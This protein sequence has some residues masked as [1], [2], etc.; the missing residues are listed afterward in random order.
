MHEMNDQD[1]AELE[2]RR[3]AARAARGRTAGLPTKWQGLRWEDLD[4]GE[5]GARSAAVAA[6]RRWAE[7]GQPRGLF[8]AGPVG[9]G[10]TRIA[11]TAAGHRVA[12]GPVRW[13][14]VAELMMKLSLGFGS[15]ERERAL[16]RINPEPQRGGG[17]LGRA[18]VLD[19]L[20][21][22]KPTEHQVAP[23]F[24]AINAW[25]EWDLLLLVTSNITLAEVERFMPGHFGPAIASRLAEHCEVFEIKGRD[26]RVEP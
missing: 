17:V 23:L 6:A 14:P 10:K 24:T 16:E 18:L 26:R 3:A 25:V 5:S 15:A 21:K 8:I 4:L 20:D 12:L 2:E 22:V 13:T 9:V 11:A 7:T 1:R 19:D